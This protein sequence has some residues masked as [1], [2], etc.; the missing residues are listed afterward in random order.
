M[1][2]SW[3][4]V[5][6][7]ILIFILGFISGIVC[8]SIFVGHKLA[9]LLR[10]PSLVAEAALEKRLTRNLNLDENQKTQIHGYFLENL[11]SRR[12]FN[13]Q[14]QPEVRAANIETFQKI[15]TVLRPDQQELFRKNLEEM[16]NRFSKGAPDAGVDNLPSATAAPPSQ[17]R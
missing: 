3:K 15:R 4:A 8:S 16:H 17:Q 2:S 5:L 7:V 14:I 12:E 10:Q 13:K 1:T 11:Q 9:A 6:G